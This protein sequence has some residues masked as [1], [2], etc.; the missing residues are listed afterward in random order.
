MGYPD[1]DMTVKY[2]V[3]FPDETYQTGSTL[4]GEA[5]SAQKVVPVT[6]TTNFAEGDRVVLDRGNA[7]EEEGV[8]D[9]ISAGVSITLLVNLAN[10]HAIAVVVE[11]IM[12]SVS[13]VVVKKHYSR[14]V[15]FIPS[16]WTTAKITFLGCLTK[17]GTFTPVV[18]G[19]DVVELEIAEVA[20]S[21]TIGLDGILME[22]L[23]NI[24][25]LKLRSGVE[26]TPVDQGSDKTIN[27]ILMR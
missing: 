12:K 20:A 16:D 18:K 2:Q 27:Y 10:T 19:T 3:T 4:D 9:S 25:Y 11:I 22:T 8:I 26:A 1:Q 7:G 13:T 15:L 5:A 14:I 21:K 24:P 17:T 6:A 23:A